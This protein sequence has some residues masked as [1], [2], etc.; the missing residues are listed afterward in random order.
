MLHR[1]AND[2]DSV[3]VLM[4]V[5]VRAVRIDVRFGCRGTDLA[6]EDAGTITQAW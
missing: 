1:D 4:I 2:E 6:M 5:M 3:A